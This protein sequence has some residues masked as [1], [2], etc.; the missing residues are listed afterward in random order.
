M[1]SILTMLYN[2]VIGPL[3]ILFEAV[4]ALSHRYFS[5]GTSI[6]ILSLVVN[7]LVLPLYKRADAIQEEE[8]QAQL[9]L[10]PGVRR[11]KKAFHGDERFM[12]L[13]TYY[14]Q[15][16]YSQLAPLKGAVPLL[17][18][19][20]FFLA[21]YRF[22]NSLQ[23]LQGAAMG[24]VHDLSRPDQ[25]IQLGGFTLNL[26][27]V[28]MTAV[29]LV[30]ASLYTRGAPLRSKIQLLVMA[31]VFLVLLYSSPAGLTVY[32]TLNNLFSL[33]KNLL[34]KIP[35]SK[36]KKSQ[37]IQ[38]LQRKPNPGLFVLCTLVLA[39]MTGLLLPSALIADSPQEFIIDQ[40]S[41]NPLWYPLHSF[42]LALGT[43]LLWM[44]IFYILGSPTM[45]KGM[46]YAGWCL[47]GVFLVDYLFFQT[48][49]G[50]ISI[51]LVY[52]AYPAFTVLR[53]IFNS[54]IV[55]MTAGLCL[56][57]VIK[58]ERFVRTTAAVL[59]IAISG[60]SGYNLVT[61]SRTVAST[62]AV[63]ERNRQGETVIPMSRKGKNIVVLMLDRAVSSYIPVIFFE[64]PELKEAFSGFT[65]YPNTISFGGSTNF[66]APG[67]FGGYEYSAWA[68][69]HRDKETIR[70]KHNEALLLMPKIFSEAG[71]MVTVF[72]P[73][74]AGDYTNATDLSLYDSLQNTN[75][76]ITLY[77][78]GSFGVWERAEDNRLRDFYCYSLSRVMP[79]IL[80]DLIYDY[81]EY[82][83]LI[84][85]GKLF[86]VHPN[87]P[88]SDVQASDPD[89][90]ASY[91]ELKNLPFITEIREEK[92]GTLLLMDSNLPHQHRVLQAPDYVVTEHADNSSYNA[93]HKERLSAGPFPLSLENERQESHYD[94]NMLT[95]ML[96][97]EWMDTLKE[98][99]VYDNTRIILVADH[100]YA[101]YQIRE[102][103][104]EGTEDIMRYNPLLM[105]KDFDAE[106]DVK[107]DPT[108]MTNADTP[109]LAMKDLIENPVNPFTGKLVSSEAKQQNQYVTTSMDNSVY[110]NCGTTFSKSRWYLVCSGAGTL[111]DASKWILLPEEY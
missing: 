32:W 42:L 2:M 11:I 64:K 3:L 66:G 12:M 54:G 50:N 73:P 82:N 16:G 80:F 33:L 99:G 10:A 84:R 85:P 24:P 106:G 71:Y 25:L 76:K 68:M 47:C 60:M 29:N 44:G 15:N 58:Q 94:I 13:Q 61:V 41:L 104:L 14:R 9:R 67:L 37:P 100:G 81:G 39:V 92:K 4:F 89:F 8:R 110:E 74:Y 27:P 20:P 98:M 17:L 93:L 88:E 79:L 18:E 109:V 22:L 43:F 30:S 28:L 53:K 31:L 105:V 72:N 75:A 21:A 62:Y 91:L 78:D 34:Q 86:T 77:E 56:L 87:L 57:L 70:D 107:T 49:L 51:S 23:L 55:L 83:K 26:L 97:A 69:N 111:F 59:V 5:I 19:I 36:M 103:M 46:E 38:F 52:D 45:K 1:M 7:I 6:V 65:Y 95:M 101:L 108:F 35:K 96:V 63:M 102:G 90:W 48:Q 40:N